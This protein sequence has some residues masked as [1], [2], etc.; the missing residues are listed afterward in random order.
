MASVDLEDLIPDLK[1]ELQTPGATTYDSV[2]N[3]EWVVRLRNAFWDAHVNGF[4]SGF[5][6]SEGLVSTLNNPSAAAMTRDQQ[7]LI[8]L[9]AGMAVIRSELRQLNTRASYEAGPV[10]YETE[11]SAQVLK[12]LLD[13]MTQR[14]N[15]LLNRLADTGQTSDVYYI[16]AYMSRQV[17]INSGLA[18]WV[19]S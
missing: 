13:D 3:E 2:S 11:K 15:Y 1:I 17:A 12:G 16:D 14:L 18:T 8:I 5:T 7:H 4:M 6:E 9:H 10:K 19:S